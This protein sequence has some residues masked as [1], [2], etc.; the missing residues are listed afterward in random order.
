M[1]SQF[2]VSRRGDGTSVVVSAGGKWRACNAVRAADKRETLRQL[3]T[4]ADIAIEIGSSAGFVELEY[5][6]DRARYCA[7]IVG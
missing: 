1:T 6:T 4:H 5:Q 3:S 7:E 2:K